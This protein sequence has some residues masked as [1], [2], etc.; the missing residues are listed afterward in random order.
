MSKNKVTRKI[1]KRI[2]IG[3]SNFKIIPRSKHWGIRNKAYGMCEPEDAKIQYNNNLKKDE[4]V[5]TILHE[6]IH[7]I[8]YMYDI[9][10]KNMKDEESVVRKLANGLHTV[11]KDN[12]NFLEWIAQN[13]NK[14]DD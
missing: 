1:P 14:K 11:F 10:F 12:P 4:L 5:N 6:V 9:P 8:V 2:K 3:Y 13:S 7:G